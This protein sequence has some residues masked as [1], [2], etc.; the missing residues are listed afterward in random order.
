M[1]VAQSLA[2]R[3]SSRS[4]R[5]KISYLTERIK[6]GDTVLIVGVSG[7]S[8]NAT[9][10][11]IEEWAFSVHGAT[12]LAYDP[13]APGQASCI[14]RG[15]ARALPFADNS[16]DY[17]I[18]NAVI[19]HVGGPEG[20]LEM[21]Q[22]SRRVARIG[23]FHTTPN[24]RFFLETHTRLPILHWAPRRFQEP[25][26]RFAGRDFPRVRYWLYSPFTLRRM[27]AQAGGGHVHRC[28]PVGMTLIAQY[29]EPAPSNVVTPP[30]P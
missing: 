19:E 2:M 6:Q 14:V 29:V 12:G 1:S 11:M 26:F 10:N 17:V 20:A 23:F 22:E 4:R 30:S 3:V 5:Q 21:L 13:P 15:D 9:E 8:R 16:F 18:S 25:I 24:R 27:L 7:G 28:G